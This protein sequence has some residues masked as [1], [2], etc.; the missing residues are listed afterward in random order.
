MRFAWFLFLCLT[1][2][3]SARRAPSESATTPPSIEAAPVAERS[4]TSVAPAW[5]HARSDLAPDP[6]I[7]WGHLENGLRYAWIAN[8]EPDQRSYLRLYVDVGSLAEEDG[9]RG[10][11]H[12]VEHMAFN[13]TEQFPGD[14]VVEWLQKHGMAFGADSNAH[15]GFSETVYELD[16]PT[17]DEATLREGL[18]VLR[19]FADG[20]TF[21]AAEVEA[22]KGVIDAEERESDSPQYR[23]FVRLL[24]SLYAG[25]RTGERVPI[26][27]PEDRRAFTP[28][29]LRRFYRRWYRPETMSVVLAGD[30]GDLDPR[31][32]IAAAFADVP[33][34]GGGVPAEPPV[35]RA[36]LEQRFLALHED[37]I[38]TVTLV[39]ERLVPW[40]D[41]P[42]TR[43]RRTREITLVAARAMLDL[44]L[45]ELAK[46]EWT[47]YIA[48]DVD[49]A[50]DGL[51]VFD[52]ENLTVVCE[53]ESWS[54]AMEVAATELRRAIE[55]G[56]QAAELEEVRADMLRGLD[57][58]VQ[59]E[60]TRTS[61]AYV[62]DILLAL[63]EGDVPMA[64]A[65]EREIL[66]P[67]VLALDVETCHRALSEAWARGTLALYTIGNLDLGPAAAEELPRVFE[68]A[69]S[70]EL[71][72]S[73]EIAPVVFAYASTDPPGEVVA[74]SRIEDFDV[75]AIEFANGVRVHV[76]ATDF[77][78]N[79]ILVRVRLGEGLLTLDS[80][81]I[82]LGR[83][84]E[85]FTQCGLREHSADDLRRLTAGKVVNVGWQIEEDHF[86]LGGSTTPEDLLLECEIACA[87]L[88]DPGWRPEGL[89]EYMKRVPQSYAQLEHNHAGPLYL[90][91]IPALYDGDPRVGL[92]SQE[93]ILA[94]T[95]DDLR[96]WLEPELASAPI[97]VYFVG[98]LDVDATVAAAARTFGKLPA[99]RA[100][101]R[102]DDRRRRNA[103]RTGL[104]ME[105]SVDTEVQKT[106]VHVVFP[107]TDGFDAPRRRRLSFL[108]EVLSDRLREE[109][110]ERLGASYSPHASAVSST[111]CPG[112]GSIVISA[113]AEPA[114][115][116][117]L[118]DACLEV[119]GALAGEG[120][121][122]EQ[123]D[124]LRPALVARLR[125]A[126]RNNGF[127][128]YALSEGHCREGALDEIRTL[129]ADYEAMQPADIDPLA[130]QYL[131]RERASVL[132][133]R[134]KD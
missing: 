1:A 68:R 115:A 76:K 15:T 82:E 129:T 38:P 28:D 112:E 84:G 91:F 32:L 106:L 54:S 5:R 62:E 105:T 16:L 20:L 59:R 11:A 4:R 104:R 120:V 36:S 94:V 30:F 53:P 14:S 10:M 103:V 125:D 87:Y 47:P 21:D 2:C 118:V 88:Q 75:D 40:V 92:P 134:P 56:F 17:S 80:S 64:A 70:S 81:R 66:R 90:E 122:A 130:E 55:H 24:E 101:Q 100:P 111:V 8:P 63:E 67:A 43:E 119:A 49:D 42:D 83:V 89:R 19:A 117:T 79:E 108:G 126:Q 93:R 78:E 58:A 72:A 86:D 37:E 35:G 46:K 99:R 48:A 95:M 61:A 96:S 121:A 39:V 44:R 123:V 26:G 25:T 27:E 7:Q 116:A 107:T 51:R 6:R 113:M 45:S 18:S 22:E 52:G 65:G 98:D 132:L 114:E 71:A 50:D 23:V 109:A 69:S 110:R 9:E 128:A 124:R 12:F 34:P 33:A 13:G 131:S 133:V 97:D 74:R 57:E 3:T 60:P 102:F 41:E 31:P 77:K 127:W 85:V 29:S 73:E